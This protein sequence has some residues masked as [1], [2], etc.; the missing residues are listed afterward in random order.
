MLSRR[1]RGL[2]SVAISSRAVTLR[3]ISALRL[4]RLVGV[5]RLGSGSGVGGLALGLGFAFRLALFLS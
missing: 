2:R 1:L 5:S 4:R 3:T